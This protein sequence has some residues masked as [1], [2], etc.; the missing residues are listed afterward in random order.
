MC[1]GRR[2]GGTGEKQDPAGIMIKDPEDKIR[3]QTTA[4][5]GPFPNA[6]ALESRR[7]GRDHERYANR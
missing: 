6:L 1:L 2:G 4:G 3:T 5:W 7:W